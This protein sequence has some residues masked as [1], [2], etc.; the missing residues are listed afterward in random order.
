MESQR[1]FLFIALAF[2]TY[3]LFVE[4][5]KDYGPQPVEQQTTQTTEVSDSN[6]PSATAIESDIP[7]SPDTPTVT[8][9]Q[10]KVITVRTDVLEVEIDTKGGDIIKASLLKYP[11]TQ[12][13]PELIEIFSKLHIA[14]S[15]LI[16][17]NG[18][19]Q[20][21]KGRPIYTASQDRFEYSS[22]ENLVVPLSYKDNN[23]LTVTKIFTFK[24][25]EYD[26][27][28][29]YQIENQ[30]SNNA[31]MQPFAQLKK[32]ILP[33]ES[34]MMMT[35][36][37]EA[38][39]STTEERYEKYDRDDMIDRPLNKTTIGGWIAMQ[40]HYFVAAWLPSATQQ[41][42][43]FSRV[44]SDGSAIIGY[45]GPV[46]T[47]APGATE[48]IAATLY[49]GP[50]DQDDLRELSETLEL[51]VDYGPLWFISKMLFAGLT[52]FYSIIPNWGI[53]IIILTIVVKFLLYPLTK[54]QTVSMAKM[55]D[56][57]PKLQALKERY[58]DD[59]AKMGPAMMEL[60]KK[61]KVNP[62]G[63]CLP[64]LL[65]MPLFLALYWMLMESVELRHA[66]FILWITDLS[67][68]DPFFI[69][70][71]LYG[72]SMYLM[73]KIQPTPITDPMQ[74]KMMQWMPV[75][76]SLL[77]VIFPAGLVLYWLVNN[78]IS[79]LQTLYIYRQIDKEKAAKAK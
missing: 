33:P 29:S 4:W 68:K 62:V 13:E 79:I 3:L 28:V 26:I 54:K 37:N 41:N 55:R 46:V 11:V 71:I 32:V 27:N 48:T 40:Q 15:G 42:N 63:G 12:G 73:Q 25:Y 17:T 7:T 45:R 9:V 35:A 56:L 53:S 75:V 39:Y 38:T 24:P 8:A 51:T 69:L 57:Q 59:R 1:S 47:V 18:P 30:T 49:A 52:F 20:T 31:V 66:E 19:D 43:I 65:Q 70:P 6:I 36:Y 50:K 23:G 21:V 64:L 61:E 16:G 5:Q 14:Q 60:Y 74:Q 77:F 58:G 44:A 78:L 72:A 67:T 2:L 34:T 76:F 10:N 22:G